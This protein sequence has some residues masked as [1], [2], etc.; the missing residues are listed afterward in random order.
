MVE[1]GRKR[2]LARLP[3]WFTPSSG[4]PSCSGTCPMWAPSS[5]RLSASSASRFAG[6]VF[7]VTFPPHRRRPPRPPRRVR[8]IPTTT[9]NP[10][11]TRRKC[12]TT[13]TTIPPMMPPTRPVT[14][15]P[16][17]NTGSQSASF[18]P[19]ASSSS[20]ATSALARGWSRGGKSGV[21]WTPSTSV[22][23]LWQQSRLA[24]HDRNGPGGWTL[25]P[26]RPSGSARSTS[27]S[28]W[29]WRPCF[30]TFYMKKSPSGSSSGN[31]TLRAV[32]INGSPWKTRTLSISWTFPVQIKPAGISRRRRFSRIVA[33]CIEDSRTQTRPRVVV[34]GVGVLVMTMTPVVTTMHSCRMAWCPGRFTDRP[35]PKGMFSPDRKQSSFRRRRG[36]EMVSDT[37]IPDITLRKQQPLI[38]RRE[39]I[40]RRRKL[41]RCICRKKEQ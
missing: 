19:S 37:A 10:S 9:W 27:Y 1:L 12:I 3:P 21:S 30:S 40:R 22:S 17:R 13:T 29:R 8:W 36:C 39:Y 32:G 16:T 6:V 38:R 5:P 7:V 14:T 20:S 28:A 24:I 2:P 34:V 35:T 23:S 33:R 41:G 31:N 25:S 26:P 15:T 11:W 4:S 18:S